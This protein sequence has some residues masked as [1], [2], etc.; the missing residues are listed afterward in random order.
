V[1]SVQGRLSALVG[2]GPV[3]LKNAIL[4]YADY[5]VALQAPNHFI[6]N[7]LPSKSAQGG[8]GPPKE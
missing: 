8:D 5:K 2:H 7:Q 6:A 3:I 4:A 1:S